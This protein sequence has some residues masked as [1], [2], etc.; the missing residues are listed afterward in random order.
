MASW[1]VARHEERCGFGHCRIPAGAPVQVLSGTHRRRVRCRA[2]AIGGV[3]EAAIE[4]AAIAAAED[5]LGE[6]DAVARA[7]LRQAF[8]VQPEFDWKAAALAEEDR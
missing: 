8:T 2:H 4:R 3:D 6:A 5:R 1:E 7:Q